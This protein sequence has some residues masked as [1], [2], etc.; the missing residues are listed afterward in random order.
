LE[1]VERGRR[2][3][4]RSAREDQNHVA[5]EQQERDLPVQAVRL[6]HAL[7]PAEERL[8]RAEPRAEDEV[9]REGGGAGEREQNRDAR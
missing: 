7:Q 1:Q 5:E 6:V 3:D 4:G 8:H 9:E 2:R